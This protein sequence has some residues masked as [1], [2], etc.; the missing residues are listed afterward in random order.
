MSDTLIDLVA[1]RY[2]L[3][4][5]QDSVARES[6]VQAIRSSIPVRPTPKQSFEATLSGLALEYMPISENRGLHSTSL[7]P[8]HQPEGLIGLD[9]ETTR[10]PLHFSSPE[11]VVKDRCLGEL[12]IGAELLEGLAFVRKIENAINR[13]FSIE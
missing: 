12:R 8:R 6:G 13:L 7:A 4:A 1:S 3:R 5:R 2:A 10:A 9:G 11:N